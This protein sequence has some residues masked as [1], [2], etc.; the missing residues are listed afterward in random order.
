MES[1][2]AWEAI[3]FNNATESS[4][5]IHA[6]DVAKQFGFRGGLVPGVTVYA[7]LVHPGLV[8]WGREWLVRGQ[9]EIVLVQPVYDGERFRVDVKTEGATS[10]A[11]EITDPSGELC[12]RGHTCLPASPDPAPTRRGDPPASPEDSPPPAERA[13]MERLR[14]QGMRSKA[15][16]WRAEPPYDRYVA[17]EREMAECV[18]PSVT[19]FAGPVFSLGVANFI[20]SANVVL[21]PWIHVE[22]R[23]QNHAVIEKGEMLQVEARILD[24]FE[25]RGHQFVDMEVGVFE[26]SGAPKVGVRH[27]AIY[28]LRPPES[29]A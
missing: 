6:D 21:G 1:P 25:R 10:Y 19:G 16:E 11:A 9:S 26:E 8:A 24:L 20:L 2:K 17:D 23:V 27:K 22:S 5:R 7:Y 12:A 18:R 3:A 14:K 29:R 28:R 15:M 13:V 4:N